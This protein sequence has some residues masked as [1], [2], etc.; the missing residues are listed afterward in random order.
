MILIDKCLQFWYHNKFYFNGVEYPLGR[1]PKKDSMTSHLIRQ[2]GIIQL[3]NEFWIKLNEGT[4]DLH[5]GIKPPYLYLCQKTE[6]EEYN[7]YLLN[8]E[9]EKLF[10]KN[11]YYENRSSISSSQL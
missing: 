2:E 8:L 3:A 11:R 4:M 5:R 9:I 7:I 6:G 1:K 10:Y